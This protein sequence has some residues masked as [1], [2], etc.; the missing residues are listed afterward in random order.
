MDT[1][2][3]AAEY[4]V[5]MEQAIA[6]YKSTKREYEA[7]DLVYI[8]DNYHTPLHTHDQ[9]SLIV[10]CFE[11]ASASSLDVL[12]NRGV[13]GISENEGHRQEEYEYLIERINSFYDK[14]SRSPKAPSLIAMHEGVSDVHQIINEQFGINV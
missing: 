13:V 6:K 7:I 14:Y 12:F 1:P 2:Y 11:H 10:T 3:S 4:M 8:I 9:F 5:Y